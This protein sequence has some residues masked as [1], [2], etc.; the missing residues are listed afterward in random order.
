MNLCHH[1]LFLCNNT[2][3]RKEEF[4]NI[5]AFIVV[6]TPHSSHVAQTTFLII[7]LNLK[8]D[9]YDVQERFSMLA[10]CSSKRG[11]EIA[12]LMMDTLEEYAIPL[13]DCRAQGYDSAADMAEKYKGA[14]A[15]IEEQ[16]SVA[17]FIPCA[18]HAL[19][20]CETVLPIAITYIGTIQAIYNLHL[21]K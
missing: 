9:R 14:Q 16:N 10:D 2:L 20:S 11:E 3:C 13:S 15:K 8:D 7:Y 19:K 5:F 6:A 1:V 17:I 21:E 12:Q 18:Y 4:T